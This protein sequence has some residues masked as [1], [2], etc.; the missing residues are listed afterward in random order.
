MSLLLHPCS[1]A[2]VNSTSKRCFLTPNH[3]KLLPSE[4]S[5]GSLAPPTPSPKKDED[6][7]A[8]LMMPRRFLVWSAVDR[9]EV[10]VGLQTQAECF[11]RFSQQP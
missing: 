2:R 11:F 4:K 9:Q 6:G 8:A 7:L 1:V 3:L 5:Y 10:S